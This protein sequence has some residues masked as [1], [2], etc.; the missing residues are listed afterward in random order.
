MGG[1]SVHEEAACQDA[2]GLKTTH[3][4]DRR[5]IGQGSVRL[6]DANRYC[7]ECHRIFRLCSA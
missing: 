4:E 7:V 1:V 2:L 5:G 6:I 3:D